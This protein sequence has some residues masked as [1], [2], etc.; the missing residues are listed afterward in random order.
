MPPLGEDDALFRTLFESAADAIVALDDR[1][2]ILLA[3]AACARLLGHAPGE[4]VGRSAEDLVPSRFVAHAAHRARFTAEP[5]T[6]A[7]GG[8]LALVALHRDGHEVPVDIALTPFEHGGRRVVFAALRDMRGSAYA[9]ETLRVQA[10]A[11][12]SAANG[13]VIT[14]RAGVVTWVNPAACAI[15]GYDADEL[16]GQHTRVLKSGEHPAEF[17]AELWRTVGRGETWSGTIVN[18]RKDGTLYDEEQTI[19][20]VVDESGALTH[21]IAIKQDVTARRRTEQALART[22][23]ELAARVAEIEALNRALREQAVRDPLTGLHNRRYFDETIAREVASSSRA[24]EPLALLAVD[25]DHFKAVNDD[26]GHAVGDRVLTAIAA[27]LGARVR[28][29]DLACRFGGEEF[30]VVLPGA[31]LPTATRRAEAL[32]REC[33]AA[34]VDSGR[35]AP[36]R[37]TVSIGV[38]AAR[39]G[40]P[41]DET[42]ARADQALYAAKGAGRDCVVAAEP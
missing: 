17:Y 30:V 9:G 2:I 29:S 41:I 28:A 25:I 8:G 21:F 39:P 6:R 22:R 33:A 27:V 11:L 24:G 26:H 34:R 42:L 10:T 14:D 3:N 32:R 20:P 19:A 1:G 18:R 36:V 15:T 4:L 37:V 31:G 5:R 13:I 38:A 7:M 40:E 16:V 35:G 23:E 12:R